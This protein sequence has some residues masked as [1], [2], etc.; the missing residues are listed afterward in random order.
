M[1]KT[2]KKSSRK[3]ASKKAKRFPVLLSTRSIVVLFILLIGLTVITLAYQ[4]NMETGPIRQ[5][6]QTS[7]ISFSDLSDS[8]KGDTEFI[9]ALKYL[10]TQGIMSGYAD[11]TFK[12][13]TTVNRAEF[14]KMLATSEGVELEAVDTPC[15]KDIAIT[16]WFA[17]AICHAKKAGWINGYPD[18]TIKPANTVTVAEALKMLITTK[19]WNLDEG[20][21]VKAPKGVGEKEWYAPYVKLAIIKNIWPAEKIKPGEK[22]TRKDVALILFRVMLVDTTK[23]GSYSNE[24]VDEFLKTNNIAPVADETKAISEAAPSSKPESPTK[25]K[26]TKK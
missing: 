4:Q 1:K 13:N 22:L 24:Q 12:A 19:E 17:P 25:K 9:A 20:K 3:T 8:D 15:A 2:A 21:D 7:V 16:D 26:A 6:L 18:G 11:N 23:V 10:K 5:K 14:I